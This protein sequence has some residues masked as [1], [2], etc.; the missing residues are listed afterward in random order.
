MSRERPHPGVGVSYSPVGRIQQPGHGA[1]LRRRGKPRRVDRMRDIARNEGS[2]VTQTIPSAHLRAVEGARARPGRPH[3]PRGVRRGYRTSG[4]PLRRDDPRDPSTGHPHEL[5]TSRTSSSC[6]HSATAVE[7]HPVPSSLT[8]APVMRL[9]GDGPVAVG[10]SSAPR[11]CPAGRSTAYRRPILRT[12][13][14]ELSATLRQDPWPGD[15]LRGGS[16]AI[17]KRTEPTILIRSPRVTA[18]LLCR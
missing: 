7:D 3:R 14:P 5:L 1:R 17:E 8:P 16:R 6:L 2:P 15:S 13:R 10:S 11:P 18:V 4:R 9:T 12:R